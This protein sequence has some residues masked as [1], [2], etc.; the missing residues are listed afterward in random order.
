MNQQ[1]EYF[2]LLE[3]IC[4]GADFL[5]NPVIKDEDYE[6]HIVLYDNLCNQAMEL[7]RIT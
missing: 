4:K 7:R 3:R 6:K 5:S 2:K 1:N